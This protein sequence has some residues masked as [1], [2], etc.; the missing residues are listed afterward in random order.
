MA[1]LKDLAIFQLK[2][3][4]KMPDYSRASEILKCSECKEEIQ[5]THRHDYV[6]CTCG[7]IFTDGGDDY[8]RYGWNPG[9]KFEILKEFGVQ[10][11]KPD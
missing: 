1:V 7:A 10:Y 9:S 8:A 11:E 6:T 5:S 3:E 4:M 2:M